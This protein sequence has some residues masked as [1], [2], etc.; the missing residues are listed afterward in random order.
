MCTYLKCIQPTCQFSVDLSH[1]FCMI[2]T[3]RASQCCNIQMLQAIFARKI[4]LLNS[5]LVHHP[6]Q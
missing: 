3:E 1:L 2:S 5:N 6:F 4:S